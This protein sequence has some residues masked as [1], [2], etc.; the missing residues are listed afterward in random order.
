ML[1]LEGEVRE[2]I[3]AVV[4][5]EPGIVRVYP[6]GGIAGANSTGFAAA[7]QKQRMANRGHVYKPLR[8]IGISVGASNAFAESFGQM[9]SLA[10]RY[11]R[12][13]CVDFINPSH[14]A[15]FSGNKIS[16]SFF[17]RHVE[18]IIKG[19]AP[20]HPENKIQVGVTNFETAKA[21]TLTV[22]FSN[23][24]SMLDALI[25]S[26]YLPYSEKGYV[27]INGVPYTDGGMSNPLPYQDV[28]GAD[29]KGILIVMPHCED[30]ITNSAVIRYGEQFLFRFFNPI[31]KR[32]HI[33]KALRDAIFNREELFRAQLG[34][35]RWQL[36]M[37]RSDP[38]RILPPTVIAWPS[39]R[40]EILDSRYHMIV[41]ALN[42]ARRDWETI[43][44][45]ALAW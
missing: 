37:E 31:V 11:R 9:R 42:G 20:T 3:G 1:C 44:H 15:W 32:K 33:S 4:R 39:V 36:A 22:D 40:V 12:F 45:Q 17:R 18:S 25:A 30:L 23:E 21:E 19:L 24:E 34:F 35:L 29:T 43:F 8:A 41:R 38:R 7:L 16:I 28:M 2:V 6:G 26:A 5:N 14:S 10:S 13:C 27:E